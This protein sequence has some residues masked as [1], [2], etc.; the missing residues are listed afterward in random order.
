MGVDTK[1][2]SNH[3]LKIPTNTKEVINLLMNS[4][5]GKIEIVNSLEIKEEDLK[6]DPI[7]CWPFPFHTVPC[8][9]SDKKRFSLSVLVFC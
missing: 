9:Q 7:N 6:L 2:Y 8:P 1:I 5:A 4:W 3:S